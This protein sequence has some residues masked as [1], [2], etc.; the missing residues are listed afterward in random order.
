M[1]DDS[2][3][4]G[5]KARSEEMLSDS[6]RNTEPKFMQK[7]RASE[8]LPIFDEEATATQFSLP[9]PIESAT[10][11]ESL[12]AGIAEDR[13]GKL[14]PF[15]T[16]DSRESHIGPFKWA[17]DLLVQD[18]TQVLAMKEGIVVEV[19]DSHDRFG[20]DPSFADDLNYITVKHADGTYSQYCHLAKSSAAVY[21]MQE[22]NAGDELARVGKTGWTDRDHLHILV[23][24]EDRQPQNEF[25]FKSLKIRWDFEQSENS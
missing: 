8:N 11:G 6:Q 20:D 5:Q 19:I 1:V 15:I 24:R 21:K 25:G 17:V 3:P 14:G 4:N 9:L 22:V 18:G 2:D 16:E 12:T 23:F 7:L 13:L 10:T